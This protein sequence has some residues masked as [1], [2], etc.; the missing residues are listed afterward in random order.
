MVPS[1]PSLAADPDCSRHSEVPTL[2]EL[3]VKFKLEEE[4]GIPEWPNLACDSHVSGSNW[5][6]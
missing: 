6:E 4:L 2:H 1:S 3:D 5:G